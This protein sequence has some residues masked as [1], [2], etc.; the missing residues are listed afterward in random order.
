M[1]MED[2]SSD[3]GSDRVFVE[4]GASPPQWCNT[5][6]SSCEKTT[7]VESRAVV[8]CWVWRA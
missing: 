1:K 5:T 8:H 3:V 2:L 4:W 6:V 7:V